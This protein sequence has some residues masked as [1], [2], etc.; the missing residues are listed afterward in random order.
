MLQELTRVGNLRGKAQIAKEQLKR[1]EG[2]RLIGLKLVQGMTYIMNRCV[3][4]TKG[5]I[6]KVTQIPIPKKE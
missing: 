5:I 1:P 3:A 4:Y 6:N 2:R